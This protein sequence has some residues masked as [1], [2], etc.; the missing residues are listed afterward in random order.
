MTTFLAI[1][2][3]IVIGVVAG[4]Y[5]LPHQAA[6]ASLAGLRRLGRL[7][8]RSVDIPGFRIA[9]LEGGKGEPLV[10]LH[11]IG[12][13]KDHWVYTAPHLTRHY[14]LIAPDVPGFGESS[15]PSDASY[16]VDDQ[17]ERLHAF[18]QKLG[19]ERAHFGGNS[20]GG[21]IV[22]NY[23]LRHPDAVASLW[24]LNTAYV[25]SA[26][27][28]EAF[29]IIEKEGRIPLF[30]EKAEDFPALVKFVMGKP[31]YMPR[32]IQRVLAEVQ[33]ANYPLNVQIFNEL[34]DKMVP[35]E[36]A[37]AGCATP[38]LIVWGDVDRV[39]HYSSAEILQKA[40]PCSQVIVMKGLGHVPML[41]APYRVAKDY[42][43]FR[44]GL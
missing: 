35:I 42:L 14:R 11:G 22:A 37:A 32:S 4:T 21:M 17:V 39:F 13:D 2:A 8:P 44:R 16:C 15:R 18:L 36:V 10:L 38:T 33:A 27:P 28:S 7:K 12:G 24:L 41:E 5:F 29:A 19:I 3:V 43:A 9:Y 20:M 40:M 1:V 23:A 6:A 34:R 25:A 31:P 30:A 26:T